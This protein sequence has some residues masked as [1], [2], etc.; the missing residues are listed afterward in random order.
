MTTTLRPS[1][2]LQQADDGTL[3]R[4][5]EVCVNS[6]PV[7]AVRVA[8]LP[9]PGRPLGTISDL[10]VDEADRGRGRGTVAALAAEEVLRG[11]RCE[12]I[13][14]SVPV[15]APAAR[16]LAGALGYVETG[17]VLA[18]DL[19]PAEGADPADPAGS[20]YLTGPAEGADPAGRAD[21]DGPVPG[22]VEIRAMTDAEAA[23]WIAAEPG[24]AALLPD[25]PATDGTRLHVAVR[26]GTRIGHLWTGWRDLPTGER[27]PYV[28]EVAV[29]EAERGRGHGRRLMRFA[30]R[31]VRGTG[32]GR[33]VLRVDPGNAPA[34]AL[35]ASL[36]YRPLLTDLEKTL[37]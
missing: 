21:P 26:G 32:G 17:H 10:R 20:T 14:V 19:G 11:W 6:R 36:G 31:V 12:R 2:P 33:L 15:D 29:A 24:R 30:E 3:A 34:R 4:S 18:K 37:Y 5:Y 35:Y 8:T 22:G 9:A 27:V 16:R 13:R 1:G 7:G 25:G 28:W 23:A